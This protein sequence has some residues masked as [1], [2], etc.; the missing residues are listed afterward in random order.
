[1]TYEVK[2]EILGFEN[3][4]SMEF[5]EVDNLF[6]TIKSNGEPI[7]FTLVNPYLL[8][9]YSFDLPNSAKVLLGIDETSNILVYNIMV[10]Q[11]P[12]NESRVN[13]L[14]PIIFNKDKG[15]MGQITLR[16]AD[17]PNFGFAEELKTFMIAA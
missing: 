9:E 7:S 12:L 15:L 10:V 8:R 6:A 3:I 4:S 17:Y 16:A 13:F 11:N 2:T 1:M 5:I 14:A